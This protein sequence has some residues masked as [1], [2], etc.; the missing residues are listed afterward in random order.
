VFKLVVQL[1]GGVALP[2]QPGQLVHLFAERHWPWWIDL[3][4]VVWPTYGGWPLF[5]AQA[6]AQSSPWY[7]C[8]GTSYCPTSTF[9]PT[10]CA[11][12]EMTC[13]K[14]V[15]PPVQ[16]LGAGQITEATEAEW[17]AVLQQGETADGYPGYTY[18]VATAYELTD[19]Q[20]ADYP[21]PWNASFIVRTYEAYKLTFDQDNTPLYEFYELCVK[22]NAP[23]VE[24][25]VQ[26]I[27]P[28]LY[29]GV[30]GVFAGCD[31][32]TEVGCHGDLDY[33]SGSKVLTD[34]KWAQLKALSLLDAVTRVAGG[35]YVQ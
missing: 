26:A 14:G 9:L 15:Q 29:C 32:S 5:Y 7:D 28:T 22:K 8:D 2:F 10:D 35:H 20:C 21:T 23:D 16:L 33:V 31:P 25:M 11:P 27:D 19:Y 18:G 4:V 30:G 1:P 24:A 13:G 6:A 12:F 3:V 17:G 34:A